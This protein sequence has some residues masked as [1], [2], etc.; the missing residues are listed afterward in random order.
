MFSCCSML[1]SLWHFIFNANPTIVG[2]LELLEIRRIAK[3]EQVLEMVRKGLCRLGVAPH[4]LWAVTLHPCLAHRLRLAEMYWQTCRNSSFNFLNLS[5]SLLLLNSMWILSN[6]R[7]KFAVHIRSL[8][9]DAKIY[10][11][12]FRI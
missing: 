9:G 11:H 4:I 10:G 8:L 7:R 3:L 2:C 5:L 6:K 1:G 12:K